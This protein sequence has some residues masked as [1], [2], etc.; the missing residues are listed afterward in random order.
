MTA[1]TRLVNKPL[2]KFDLRNWRVPVVIF[3]V[4]G[5]I[6][7]F[8][9]GWSQL[10]KNSLDEQYGVYSSGEQ[11]TWRGSKLSK[12][13][14]DMMWAVIDSRDDWW[15]TLPPLFTEGDHL[16]MH[17]LIEAGVVVYYVTNRF[18]PDNVAK[19]TELWLIEH[20][21]PVSGGVITTT[22]KAEFVDARFRADPSYELLGAIDDS[23]TNLQSYAR[24]NLPCYVRDWR[25]N[26]HAVPHLPRVSS[27]AEFCDVMLQKRG[28]AQEQ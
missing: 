13:E 18:A 14:R 21:L 3:D 25:Y 5:V 20:S 4:D 26:R 19:Q 1:A 15:V 7:D 24:L 23:P 6:C 2:I 9:T 17:K 22:E 10:V 27:V 8:V 11:R 16:A 12:V 28:F